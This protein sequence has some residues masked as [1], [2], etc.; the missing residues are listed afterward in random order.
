MFNIAGK[1]AENSPASLFHMS[2]QSSALNSPDITSTKMPGQRK[3]S[4]KAPTL[5][6]K[7]VK[8]DDLHSI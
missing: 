8:L 1:S 4:E 5:A 7:P 2:R 6:L 3:L